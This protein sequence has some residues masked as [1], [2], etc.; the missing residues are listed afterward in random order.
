MPEQIAFAYPGNNR[1]RVLSF[2]IADLITL[3]L[4]EEANQNRFKLSDYLS[5]QIDIDE[6]QYEMMNCL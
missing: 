6:L 5:A 3:R 2:I 4:Q 1:Q